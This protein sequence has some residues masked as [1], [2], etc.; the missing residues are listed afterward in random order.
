MV[1]AAVTVTATKR[2]Q[3]LNGLVLAGGGIPRISGTIRDFH[4]NALLSVNQF[5]VL[6]VPNGS[7]ADLPLPRGVVLDGRDQHA[8]GPLSMLLQVGTANVSTGWL[9]VYAT[10][11]R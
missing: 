8:S 2:L 10:E 3:Q 7:R 9:G 11:Y 1:G 5:D 4:A 6:W